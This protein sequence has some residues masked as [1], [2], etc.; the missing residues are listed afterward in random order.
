[1][2]APSSAPAAEKRLGEVA[3]RVEDMQPMIAFYRDVIQLTL[4][5]EK[6]HMAFFEIAPGFAGH[7]SVLALF[8][9]SVD[10]VPGGS[11]DHIAFSIALKDFEPEVQRLEAMG[12]T[13]TRKQHNWMQW[14]SMYIDDPEGNEVEF[15]CF[16]P[17]VPKNFQS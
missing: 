16:D 11:L 2:N 8:H 6:K 1:M 12:Y 9:R 7:T 14:R 10:P 5:L 4:V 3:L 15:V 17:S 13:V